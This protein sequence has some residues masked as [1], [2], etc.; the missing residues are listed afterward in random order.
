MRHI[1]T[2]HIAEN[3]VQPLSTFPV[4]AP[5]L[6]RVRKMTESDRTEVLNFLSERP[7]HTVVMTSFI[8]DNGMVSELNRGDF[9]GF[10]DQM[11]T[12]Q[13]VALIG[14]STLVEARPNDA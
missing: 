13:G 7:V 4:L 10:A 8:L 12:L 14:H 2:Q 6:A 5:E 1:A 11:G 3:V 9:Y